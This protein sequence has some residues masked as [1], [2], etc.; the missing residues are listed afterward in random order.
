MILERGCCSIDRFHVPPNRQYRMSGRVYLF[1]FA[2]ISWWWIRWQWR[3]IIWGLWIFSWRTHYPTH[4]IW[5][6]GLLCH[7]LIWPTKPYRLHRDHLKLWLHEALL[8]WI[9]SWKHFYLDRG[10]K[11]QFIKI[12]FFGK[13]MAA[14]FWFY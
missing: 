7:A 13:T 2:I 12:L 5:H 4:H 6:W 11:M 9:P 8:H 3:F 10:I 1:R 14:C